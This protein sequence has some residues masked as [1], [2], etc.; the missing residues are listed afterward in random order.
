MRAQEYLAHFKERNDWRTIGREA[1]I[2]LVYEDDCAS[3]NASRIWTHFASPWE[4]FYDD[5]N[6]EV[7]LGVKNPETGWIITTDAGLG[8]IEIISPPRNDL[9][10]LDREF[11]GVVGELSRIAS[12][13]GMRLLGY[14]AQ[15]VTPGS[16]SLWVPKGRYSALVKALGDQFV[17]DA[18]VT[19]SDQC[20]VSITQRE[21]LQSVNVMNALSGAIVALTANS[22][23]S[24][25]RVN[26]CVSWRELFWDKFHGFKGQIGIP[27]RW[28]KSVD[29]WFN[30]LIDQR[31]VLRR[32][33]AG[34]YEARGETFRE[35]MA[36][37]TVSPTD[38]L[39]HEGC[40]WWDARP[41][42]PYS[43]V[44]VR[45]ACQQPAHEN[46]VVEA[47]VLGL[48]NNLDEAEKLV[49]KF[50]HEDWISYRIRAAVSG[51]KA[52]FQNKDSN[53]LLAA[54]LLIAK[55]GLAKRG[56]C[57]E[58]F[59]YPLDMRLRNRCL[60]ADYAKRLWNKDKPLPFIDW[61]G[62]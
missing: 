16:K 28:F 31:F 55:Q 49:T 42:T 4:A 44:E 10:T 61:L 48:V 20:H 40:C 37:N 36:S 52:T 32:V 30:Y 46:S 26:G 18:T 15:P 22:P 23:I 38:F 29:E 53:L 41:R 19:A 5:S 1:E 7:C 39:Y 35:Y 25:G 27:P 59:L 21:V 47:L 11:N 17:H 14:G 3:G 12:P 24:Y 45:P 8:I 62:Y 34:I 33:Q 54:V 56:L 9:L 51:L 13:L 50:D 2:P 57:E 60:P 58:V 6:I 43:T